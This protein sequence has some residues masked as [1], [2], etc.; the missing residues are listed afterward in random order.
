MSAEVRSI[1][2][3]RSSFRTLTISEDR[4][5]AICNVRARRFDGNASKACSDE[6]GIDGAGRLLL[7]CCKEGSGV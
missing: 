1:R 4:E 2:S 7:V 5:D 6:I 3:T